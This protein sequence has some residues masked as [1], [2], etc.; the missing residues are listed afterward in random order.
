MDSA[1]IYSQT[2]AQLG[3]TLI[4]M[5]SPEWD[6]RLQAASS[7]ERQDAAKL[8][9]KTQHAR[10]VLGN[11]VLQDIAEKL[12]SNENDLTAGVNA[13]QG[14]L[15]TVASVTSV[16]NTISSFLTIVSRVVALV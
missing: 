13:L 14:T 6:N 11:A 12:K 8:M 2:L 15:A 16:L 4:T 1:Q 7:Q 3:E 9:I 10:L 5:T